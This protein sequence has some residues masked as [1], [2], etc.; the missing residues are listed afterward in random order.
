MAIK[1]GKAAIPDWLVDSGPLKILVRMDDPWAP[2]P[3]P[4]WPA[5]GSSTTVD[6][7]GFSG[8]RRRGSKRSLDVLGWAAADFLRSPTSHVCGRCAGCCLRSTWRGHWEVA[9]AIDEFLHQH[10][11]DALLALT[12]SRVA[13][14]QI[15]SLMIRAGLPW[16]DLAAAHDDE[17]PP[18]SARSAI[19]A[20]L[21]S[22][23]DGDWSADEIAPRLTSAATRVPELLAGRDPYAADGRLD[24]SAEMFRAAPP[25]CARSSSVRPAWSRRVC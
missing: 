18:W 6:G 24:Q 10:P 8:R 4:D 15:P 9:K 5:A 14:E 7:E 13:T 16:A 23:A 20:T 1:A 17:P 2:A 25:A 19:A 3:V 12:S 22:A 21:L 11:R